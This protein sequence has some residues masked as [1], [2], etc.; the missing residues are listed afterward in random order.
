MSASAAFTRDITLPLNSPFWPETV[1][2]RGLGESVARSR[3]AARVWAW[4]NTSRLGPRWATGPS[5]PRRR[6][7]I[8]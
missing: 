5:R 7:V 2:D 1:T 8:F 6:T 4:D 3:D